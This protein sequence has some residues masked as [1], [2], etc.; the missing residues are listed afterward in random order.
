MINKGYN[1]EVEINE[2]REERLRTS[3]RERTSNTSGFEFQYKQTK[4]AHFQT[5]I[6]Q[7]VQSKTTF[8]LLAL[9]SLFFK[10][11]FCKENCLVHNTVNL[12]KGG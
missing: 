12:G 2:K 3:A 10:A 1:I 8:T 7:L 11:L 5:K 6:M 4:V 9:R